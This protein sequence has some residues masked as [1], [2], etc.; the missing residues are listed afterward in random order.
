MILTVRDNG[1][2]GLCSYQ[3]IILNLLR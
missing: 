2:P 1:T 3:R